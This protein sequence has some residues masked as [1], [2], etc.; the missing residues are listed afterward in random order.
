M[1]TKKK[2]FHVF[3]KFKVFFFYFPPNYLGEISDEMFHSSGEK[4]TS[5]LFCLQERFQ[6]FMGECDTNFVDILFNWL[7]V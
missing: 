7:I 5:S 6:S 3:H 4:Q 1:P 2:W